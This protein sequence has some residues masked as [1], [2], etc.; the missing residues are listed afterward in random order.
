[1]FNPDL[2]SHSN[3]SDGTLPPAVVVARAARRGVSTLA[4]TDHDDTG[5]LAEA[6]A[7]AAA[8]GLQL[9]N[10]V[11]ISVSWQAQTI[12]VV[13]LGIDPDDPQLQA[14]LAKTRAG[15]EGRAQRMAAAFDALGIEGTLAGARRCAGN[16]RMIG[17]THFARHLVESGKVKS[18]KDAFRR[19]LGAG[20]PC[21]VEQEW[22]ALGEAVAWI[23]GS[24]GLAVVAHPGRY[25][26]APA[27]LRALLGEFRDHGGAAIEVVT[28]SHQ[29]QEFAMFAKYAAEFGLAGSVGS[30]FHA[31]DESRDLGGLPKLPAGCDPVWRQLALH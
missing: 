19:W 7:A 12:H 1:M 11:E 18:I 8:N 24:G 30:D 27:Q 4:L 3:I 29:P 13:G 10:G 9:I 2:H 25:G 5:G 22:A 16:P 6:V 28:G 17:R 26:L 20:R 23:K 21:Q 14:G 15:R 31:P